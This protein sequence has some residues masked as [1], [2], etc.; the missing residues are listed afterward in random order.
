MQNLFLAMFT[1][2]LLVSFS[3]ANACDDKKEHSDKKR[4]AKIEACLEKSRGDS[5]SYV[6]RKRN[7]EV[8]GTCEVGRKDPGLICLSDRHKKHREA[9]NEL[10]KKDGFIGLQESDRGERHQ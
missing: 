10:S 1:T 4:A 3:T 2:I 9:W 8:S 5:C 7:N 6:K